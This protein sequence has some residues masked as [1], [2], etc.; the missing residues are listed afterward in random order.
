M[1]HVLCVCVCMSVCPCACTLERGLDSLIHFLTMV[2]L[3]E[4][5]ENWKGKSIYFLLTILLII[6][7]YS[8][9]IAHNFKEIV[10]L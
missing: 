9:V 10:P 1:S 7:L 6:S 2:T 8:Y 3:G 4:Q 5:S